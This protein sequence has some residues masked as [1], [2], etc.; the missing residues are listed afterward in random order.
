MMQW[1]RAALRSISGRETFAAIAAA[2]YVS[3]AMA[4]CPPGSV[5]PPDSP[6]SQ[7]AV[8]SDRAAA[9]DSPSLAAPCRC[10]CEPHKSG[11][12]KREPGLAFAMPPLPA[13][14]RSFDSEIAA[15][16]PDAPIFVSS[17][18]PIAA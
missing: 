14:A 7:H 2:A 3:V 16:L 6:H 1:T 11:L 17:R 18:I 12:G 13:L 10:G 4:P 8:K 9:E 5:Q 15:R